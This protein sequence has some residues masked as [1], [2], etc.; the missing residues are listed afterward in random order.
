M[1]SLRNRFSENSASYGLMW[2]SQP[3]KLSTT[4]TVVVDSTSN[5]VPDIE[6]YLV[7]I[8]GNAVTNSSYQISRSV[9]EKTVH[10]FGANFN[11]IGV[12][13]RNAPLGY[14][15]YSG[16]VATCFPTGNM[17]VSYSTLLSHATELAGSSS[18]TSV[19]AIQ[20]WLFSPCQSGQVLKG[21][22]CVTCPP[23]KCSLT[24]APLTEGTNLTLA[25]ST[26]QLSSLECK[27]YPAN[28]DSIRTEGDKVYVDSGY[29]RI[30]PRA[31]D[32]LPCPME[33]TACQFCFL[34]TVIFN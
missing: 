24:G 33:K 31:Y 9:N 21:G 7:D 1:D 14:A 19:T 34:K 2:A 6:V 5:V 3:M 18:T 25:Y 16:L 28:A 20:M 29:W 4:P 13:T 12:S 26:E 10:C 17:T 23:G 8:F 27:I 22:S 11:V 30:S 32:L 15:E